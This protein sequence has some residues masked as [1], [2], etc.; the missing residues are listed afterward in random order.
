M[1]SI[2]ELEKLI[3]S[4]LSSEEIY[5][6]V[7]EL[8]PIKTERKY[9]ND[10][11]E[12]FAIYIGG[13]GEDDLV[14]INNNLYPTKMRFDLKE[15]YIEFINLIREKI[16]DKENYKTFTKA[17]LASIRNLSR[18]WFYMQKTKESQKNAE[19]AQLYINEYKN[20]ARQR[21][22]YATDERVSTINEE[23]QEIVYNLSKFE[24]T[25]DLA[26]CVEVNSLACNL[27]AFSGFQTVL[28]Q[29]YFV[30]HT[31]KKEAHTFPL[32][33]EI[34]GDYNLLDCMLKYQRQ[35]VL[36]KDIDFSQGFSIEIPVTLRYSDNRVESSTIT[37]IIS[38]QKLI[39]KNKKRQ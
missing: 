16:K 15:V 23:N 9:S 29:G 19:L 18:N 1:Y 25:G 35:D 13:I 21:D 3:N 30:N 37:Y 24:G 10:E 34:D 27:L 8:N 6:I 32:Y 11:E 33:K 31:G 36:S 22:G 7:M 26:K 20:A 4:N 39:K 17:V 14:T 38:P 2:N 28:V 12:P 5:K